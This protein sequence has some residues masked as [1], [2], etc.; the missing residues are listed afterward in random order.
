MLSAG[1][2]QAANC[3]LCL[4]W[5]CQAAGPE[6]GQRSLSASGPQGQAADDDLPMPQRLR[7]GAAAA[8]SYLLS[9]Y[10]TAGGPTDRQLQRI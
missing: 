8:L 9:T 10:S 2:A 1:E 6:H 4:I 3:R 5:L 7:A